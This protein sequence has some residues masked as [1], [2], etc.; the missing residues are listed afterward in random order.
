M[1]CS[2]TISNFALIE[3]AN[4]EFSPQLNIITG[5]TGAGKSIFIEALG[6]LLG[7]RASADLIRSG[8]DAL[9][10]EAVFDLT[11]RNALNRLL[12]ELEIPLEDDDSLLLVRRISRHGKNTIQAN[13]VQIPLSQLKRLSEYLLD[14]HGQHENQA[15][16]R[17]GTYLSLID[18]MLPLLAQEVQQYRLIY[19]KWQQLATEIAALKQAGRDRERRI[20]I[21]KWQTQEI[22]TA[23][24]QKNEENELE[25]ELL[26]I[27]N[28]EK[29]ASGSRKAYALLSEGNSDGNDVLSLLAQAGKELDAIV[30]YQPEL[31]QCRQGISDAFFLLQEKSRELSV[32]CDDVEFDA[33]RLAEVQSRLDVIDK[34]KRKYGS[35]IEEILDFQEKSSA[36]LEILLHQDE[37]ITTLEKE[38]VEILNELALK[39]ET[40]RQ[41]REEA[42]KVLVAGI[43]EHLSDLG[44]PH[45]V[46]EIRHDQKA[47]YGPYG[48]DEFDFLFSANPG[49]EIRP[50]HKVASGGEL[51]RIA[52]AIKS[53]GGAIDAPSMIFDE[54]DTGIGGKTAQMVADKILHLSRA[55]QIICITHLPQ[56][57][58]A[59]DL[60]IYIEKIQSAAQ[61]ISKIRALA[62]EE[63][64]AEL[65]RMSSGHAN[66]EAVLQHARELLAE[67]AQKKKCQPCS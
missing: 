33:A 32:Y 27:T 14:M 63:Q 61:T 55:K 30:R 40:L 16:L 1:L 57:A 17:P 39:A 21:L 66:S 49:E 10:V 2:L 5:E 3:A 31:E 65:A 20:D 64:V 51:S 35:D 52:L 46:F 7:D 56:I 24:L 11:G 48:K 4:I 19:Q 36:E 15:L 22:A 29:I 54:I 38:Q 60:H 37:K 26:K 58:S 59:A 8:A 67:A 25:A 53:M 34:M 18:E 9:R 50:L 28:L 23:A 44:L 47:D 62:Q 12:E 43:M 41:K 45:A 42:A 6:V 13:G